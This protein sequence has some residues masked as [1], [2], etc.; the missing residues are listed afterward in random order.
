LYGRKLN[1]CIRT[2]LISIGYES[3]AFVLNISIDF[4]WS[5]NRLA[6]ILRYLRKPR[7]PITSTVL[8]THS[9]STSPKATTNV[10]LEM[11]AGAVSKS[12]SDIVLSTLAVS[13][14]TEWQGHIGRS[15]IG[16]TRARGWADFQ[17]VP[18]ISMVANSTFHEYCYRFALF[19]R[20]CFAQLQMWLIYLS[21][22]TPMPR[23]NESFY[24]T[25]TSS[26]D[27]NRCSREL[28]TS[29]IKNHAKWSTTHGLIFIYIS[30]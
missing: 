16:R 19:L 3:G 1:F 11:V 15:A 14:Y 8:T 21:T 18:I 28:L 7:V 26:N 13:L 25:T 5:D 20:S 4:V 6:K 27:K 9:V 2:R 22:D 17:Y 30:K 23:P 24:H 12:K 29:E 10:L